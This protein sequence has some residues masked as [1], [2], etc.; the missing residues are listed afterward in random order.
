VLQDE[1][2]KPQD[3]FQRHL[4][5]AI[6]VT[7]RLAH[8][9]SNIL[10]GILGFAELS[11]TQLP[12]DSP[13]RPYVEEIVQ[14]AENGAGWV[15]KLQAFGRSGKSRFLPIPLAPLVAR[16]EE[17]LRQAWDNR[18]T[19]LAAL[20]E[21]LPPLALDADSLQQL[22]GQILDNAC[23]AVADRGV[24][25][26]SARAVELSDSGCRDLFGNAQPGKHVEITIS[27]SGIGLSEATRPRLVR[28][29][30]FST[31]A[32]RRGLGLALVQSILH[33]FKGG[34]CFGPDPAQGTTVR[35]F[36]PVA[37]AEDR[38][39]RIEDRGSLNQSSI[40]NPR[41]SVRILV[42]DDDP[43]IL[44]MACQVLANAGFDVQAAAGP[45]EAIA[46]CQAQPFRLIV[47]DIVM[48]NMSGFE[49]VRQ[50]QA[51][52][53]AINVLFIS[54]QSSNGVAADALLAQYPLLKKPFAAND[55]VQAAAA[56]LAR[57]PAPAGRQPLTPML[58]I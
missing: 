8:D 54:S 39:S 26:L 15:R 36:L 17:R 38:G 30:F 32:R 40:L 51:H 37:G 57:A 46:L 44:R 25:T 5:T 27:D 19:F 6:L 7:G 29:L 2:G 22:L 10:T 13:A 52:D 11:L 4:E 16:E 33:R 58:D 21:D 42:V 47:S 12:P 1:I 55:L 35:L 56:A 48:P 28:E 49:M 18:V 45:Q 53:R 31:K 50:L 41:S 34:L 24:V 43:E 14:F 23:E 3:G 20:P 9:F